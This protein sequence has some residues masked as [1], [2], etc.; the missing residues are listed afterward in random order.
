MNIFVSGSLAYDRIMNFPGRFGDHILPDRIHNLNVSFNVDSLVERPGG[1]AGNISYCLVLL[2]RA[3]AHAG[4]HRERLQPVPG[5]D[6]AERRAAQRRQGHRRSAPTASAYITTDQGD[7]Q[8]TGFHM[9]AM[10]HTSDFSFEDYEPEESIAV[11]SPGNLDD[12]RNYSQFYKENGIPYVFDPGQS[13]P[14]WTGDALRECID[15]AAVLIANDYEMGL[16]SNSTGLGRRRIGPIGRRGHH[17]E[18]RGRLRGVGG[19][20]RDGD[21]G[22]DSETGRRPNGRWRLVPWRAAQGHG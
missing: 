3:A 20:R 1:C 14:A 18:G 7:N 21:P 12:M 10:M 8:I 19:R 9:G 4:H 17:N 13:L 2:G 16:I 5:M 6:G 22:C 15:G 11:V